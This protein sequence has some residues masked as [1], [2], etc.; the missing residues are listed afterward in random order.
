M[1]RP[2]GFPRGQVLLALVLLAP[3]SAAWGCRADVVSDTT[4]SPGGSS[5]GG[6]G[7]GS[8][9]TS[10]NTSAPGGSG[11]V[12]SGYTLQTVDASPR[13]AIDTGG[14]CGNQNAE[15][16]LQPVHLAFVF[17]VSGSMGKLDQSYHD[18]KL[19]WDPVVAATKGFFETSKDL[20]ASMTFFPALEEKCV[21]LSYELPTV[22]FT[23][24]PSKVFGEA[25]D[26]YRA[27]GWRG[28]TPTLHALRGVY[29]YVTREMLTRPGRYVMVLVTDGYPEQCDDNSIASV[30]AE[31]KNIA[32]TM[33]LYV[34]GVKNPKGG[35]DTVS[36]LGVV[37]A[38]GETKEAFFINTGDPAKTTA[39]FQA[40]IEKIRGYSVS[41][42]LQIPKP[43]AGMAFQKENVAVSTSTGGKVT[44]LTYDPKCESPN[45]WYYDAPAA[46]TLIRLCPGICKAIQDD[47]STKI[48]I[49]FTCEPV[50]I[51]VY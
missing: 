17:D 9:S 25:L 19:K 2:D 31:A 16:S 24:L 50:I 28:R 30:V 42:N 6:S 20:F 43:P 18:P 38:A 3:L 11:F 47:S 45:A 44:K 7:S 34:V 15:A 48:N 10:S 23:A 46:P 27:E 36:D 49:E 37:A 35:P 32:T 5:G 21:D 26:A 22:P 8:T 29:A 41:C 51:V 39:D 14:V 4:G 13:P 40:A 33:P 1:N 12:G